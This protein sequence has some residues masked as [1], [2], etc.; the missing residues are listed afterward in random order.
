MPK[1]PTE[2][3]IMQEL[4]P[5]SDRG[6][7]ATFNRLREKKG[8]SFNELQR[9]TVKVDFERHKGMSVGTLH[10]LSE[11]TGNP[12]LRDI[13][14]LARA[15]GVPAAWFVLEEPFFIV[16]RRGHF[17]AWENTIEEVDPIGKPHHLMLERHKY[18][19]AQITQNQS[20]KAEQS[21]FEHDE[22]WAHAPGG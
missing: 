16:R 17:R 6:F 8:L 12:H 22:Q 2:P 15:L 10:R 20:L 5:A 4:A 1:R 7:V 3:P 21:G 18:R 19:Y 13:Q 9:L 14:L 11:G